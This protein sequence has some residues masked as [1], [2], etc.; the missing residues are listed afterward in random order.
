M[1]R[2]AFFAASALWVE[3]ATTTSGRLPTSS[4]ANAGSR[5]NWPAAVW[6]SIT[7]LRP[8]T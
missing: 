2:V 7:R 8:S 4:A 6:K 5:S 1:V 3:T